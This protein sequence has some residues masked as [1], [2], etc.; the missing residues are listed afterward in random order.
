MDGTKHVGIHINHS[1][2]IQKDSRKLLF[3]NWKHMSNTASK[4]ANRLIV[5]NSLT[6]LGFCNT[7][8][9]TSRH[10]YEGETM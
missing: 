10:L 6:E 1:N 8:S 4:K 2:R 3:T 9:V 5:E 7:F